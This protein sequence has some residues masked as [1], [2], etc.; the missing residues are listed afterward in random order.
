MKAKWKKYTLAAA[1]II[2]LIA[3]LNVYAYSVRHVVT[4]GKKFGPLTKPFKTFIE[5]PMLVKQTFTEVE[6]YKKSRYLI[7]AD[8]TFSKTNTL[9]Y[10]LF[11][12]NAHSQPDKYIYRLR[13]LKNDSI[14]H[15]W[16]FSKKQFKGQDHVFASSAPNHPILMDDGSLIGMIYETKNLFRINKN[17]EVMWHNTSGVFH[18][19]LNLSHDG[20]LWTSTIEKVFTRHTPTGKLI[21]MEDNMLV[22][23][24]TETGE[25]VYKKSLARI[26]IRHGYRNL[27]YGSGN[28]E[29]TTG[30]DPFHL[31][32][33]Q[34]VYSESKYYN[35]GD[36][37]L[38]LR[39]RSMIIQY[40]PEADT[41]VRI[42]TG[43]FFEQHDVDIH[44]PTAI[45]LF[46][47]NRPHTALIS[48]KNAE[49]YAAEKVIDSISG[50]DIVLYDFSDSTFRKPYHNMLKRNGMYSE[51]QGNHRFLSNG[52]L[53]VEAT[54]SGKVL[55]LNDSTIKY[56]NYLNQVNDEGLVE[57]PHWVRVYEKKELKNTKL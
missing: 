20:F 51:R 24:N 48:K 45:S 2:L 34:P 27:L 40:R 52:D 3:F 22:K 42:I 49:G 53:F 54:E 11:V 6:D 25:I 10:D 4:G 35:K 19:S 5:F 26:L 18:H 43:Q 31:N 50:S 46:S 14:L 13:N 15:T 37:F 56:E 29:Y 55:I 1:K 57:Y 7:P 8:S 21:P 30:Q 12:L 33:V 47:N 32:D 9:A 36:L 16:T 23:V 41:I 39:H 44:S 38:S 17:S 28:E